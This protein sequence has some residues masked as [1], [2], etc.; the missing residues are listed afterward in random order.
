MSPHRAGFDGK[1]PWMRQGQELACGMDDHATYNPFPLKIDPQKPSS[2]ALDFFI[3]AA[4]LAA[5]SE[6][7]ITGL[8]CDLAKLDIVG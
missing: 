8:P 7:G 2:F 5:N 6:E 4:H 1:S 3:L